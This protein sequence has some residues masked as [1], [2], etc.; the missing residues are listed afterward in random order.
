[1]CSKF[2]L[3][4][5]VGKFTKFGSLVTRFKITATVVGNLNVPKY[6]TAWMLIRITAATVIINAAIKLLVKFRNK[7]FT[8][9]V[10]FI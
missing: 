1:M 9:K 10:K 2:S 6:Y 7:I 3:L 8:Y 4:R 5:K